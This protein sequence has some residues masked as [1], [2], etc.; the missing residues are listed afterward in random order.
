[1]NVEWTDQQRINEFSK[2]NTRFTA[3]EA[4]LSKLKENKEDLDDLTMDIELVDDDE[5]LLYHIGDIFAHMQKV[6]IVA[7]VEKDSELLGEQI[8][9]VESKKAD[10]SERMAE[11]KD[12]LYAKFGR[13]NINLERD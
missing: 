13:E 11:L 1:M 9:D 3:L 10:I 8:S 7:R 6:D 12:A 4:K 5:M 2:L